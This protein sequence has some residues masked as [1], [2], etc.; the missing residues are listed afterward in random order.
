MV[1]IK[2]PGRVDLLI[3]PP[4]QFKLKSK[5]T[6]SSRQTSRNCAIF[7]QKSAIFFKNAEDEQY[8]AIKV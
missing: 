5:H 7:L 6:L 1:E 8:F 2:L 3:D 4:G